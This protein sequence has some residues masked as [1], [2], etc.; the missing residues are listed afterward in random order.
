[1]RIPHRRQAA[2]CDVKCT[3]DN[4][5]KVRPSSGARLRKRTLRN[6]QGF[7]KT[8]DTGHCSYGDDHFHG[9]AGCLTGV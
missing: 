3:T 2:V 9:F 5:P 1:M 4:S 7:V 8:I 6:A